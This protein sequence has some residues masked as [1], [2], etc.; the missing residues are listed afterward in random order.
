MAT[1]SC[2][3][4]HIASDLPLVLEKVPF[5]PPSITV[6]FGGLRPIA[7]NEAEEPQFTL[8]SGKL[9]LRYPESGT[10]TLDK[11]G[12]IHATSAFDPPTPFFYRFVGMNMTALLLAMRGRLVLHGST[13]SAP[14]GQALIV[15]RSGAGKS[16]LSLALHQSGFP[17]V[18]DDISVIRAGSHLSVERG[19]PYL[20]AFSDS[21]TAL[22]V[23]SKDVDR[24][25]E[26]GPK[27]LVPFTPDAANLPLRAIY[28]LDTSTTVSVQRLSF[29]EAF[30]ALTHHTFLS[31]SLDLLGLQRTHFSN[32]QNLLRQV[33]VFRITRTT[34]FRSLDDCIRII[35][36]G[37]AG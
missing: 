19:V 9:H 36:S 14:S 32:V 17:L 11:Q 37:A 20:K 2:F 3:G 18:C 1:Y 21:L 10:F 35:S 16:S 28:V 33:D 4:E 30:T 24:L 27:R 34:D 7:E 5:A 25:T 31:R 13:V 22:D 26:H 6:S 8:Q 23:S 29:A 15:G 12:F